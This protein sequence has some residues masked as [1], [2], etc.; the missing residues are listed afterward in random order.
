MSHH[1]WKVK[2]C[3]QPKLSTMPR[4][5]VPTSEQGF[6]RLQ[7]SNQGQKRIREVVI[8]VAA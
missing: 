4:P 7:W 8:A 2:G 6:I 1:E 3:V 5:K